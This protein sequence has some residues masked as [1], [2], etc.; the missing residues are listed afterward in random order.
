MGYDQSDVDLETS[1]NENYDDAQLTKEDRH[2]AMKKFRGVVE[3]HFALGLKDR[4]DLKKIQ[5]YRIVLPNSTSKQR[6]EEISEPPPNPSKGEYWYG[7]RK[8][9]NMPEA[10]HNQAIV[11]VSVWILKPLQYGYR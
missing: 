3:D 9:A 4:N 6:K 7:R 5:P 2:E 8:I 11:N 10:F 1:D